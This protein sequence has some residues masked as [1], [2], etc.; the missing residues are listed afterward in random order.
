MSDD[1]L[2]SHYEQT[3][4]A[5]N[6]QLKKILMKFQ[7][8]TFKSSGVCSQ[9]V[10]G[11]HHCDILS[12]KKLLLITLIEYSADRQVAFDFKSIGKTTKNFIPV[13]MAIDTN[14][15]V[16]TADYKHSVYI[17]NPKYGNEMAI[18]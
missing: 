2:S 9:R 13:G 6:V 5:L 12:V 4:L 16:Y 10:A 17:I 18:Q 15:F 1:T 7:S 11:C 14:G 3:P 8:F